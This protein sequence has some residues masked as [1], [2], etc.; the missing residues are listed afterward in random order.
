MLSRPI[1]LAPITGLVLGDLHGGLMLAPA[2]ELLWLGAVTLGAAIPAQESLGTVSITGAAVLAGGALG[3]GVTPAVCVLALAIAAPMALVGRRVD[4]LGEWTNEQ[5]ARRAAEQ[6][7]GRNADGAVQLNLWGL[8]LPF[9]IGVALAPIGAAVGALAIPAI[10]QLQGSL[11]WLRTHPAALEQALSTA[12]LA[13]SIFSCGAGA[14]ALRS[15]R[16][17]PLFVGALVAGVI[18]FS[19]GGLRT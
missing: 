4:W 9:A 16:A 1:A 3:T 8:V 12:W 5:L 15:K 2:L 19:L 14:R 7:E 11:P 10:F 13:F 17:Q 6:I 18:L